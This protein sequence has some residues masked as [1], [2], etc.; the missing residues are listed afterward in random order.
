MP[1][2]IFYEQNPWKGH[3]ENIFQIKINKWVKNAFIQIEN[4]NNFVNSI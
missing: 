3:K 1:V 4:W 2:N